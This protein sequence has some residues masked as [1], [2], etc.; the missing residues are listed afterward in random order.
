MLCHIVWEKFTNISEVLTASI[1]SMVYS[2]AERVFILEHYFASKSF[3]AIREAFGNLYLDKEVL[4]KT[5]IH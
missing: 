4:N 1:I 3:V 5:T 2:Q